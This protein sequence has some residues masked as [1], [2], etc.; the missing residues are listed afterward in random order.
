MADESGTVA[1]QSIAEMYADQA[2]AA[3]K[4]EDIP[5]FE[6][7]D[8]LPEEQQP[9]TNGSTE[10]VIDATSDQRD[11]STE[12]VA[13]PEDSTESVDGKGSAEPQAGTINLDTLSDSDFDRI[14]QHPRLVKNQDDLVRRVRTDIDSERNRLQA[15]TNAQAREEA[16]LSGDSQ[17]MAE[18]QRQ[19]RTQ[20][21]QQRLQSTVAMQI[22]DGVHDLLALDKTVSWTDED[23]GACKTTQDIFSRWTAKLRASNEADIEARAKEIADARVKEMEDNRRRGIPAPSRRSGAPAGGEQG[24]GKNAT[25]AEIY[26][27]ERR[28]AAEA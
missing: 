22:A 15:E 16:I 25:V 12:P 28:L 19:E 6:P 9:S 5:G 23:K 20:I 7:G 8:S 10:P 21:L 2:D 24:P 4:T 1:V 13:A 17:R 26:D 18:F 27:Y 14:M 3:K 11:G